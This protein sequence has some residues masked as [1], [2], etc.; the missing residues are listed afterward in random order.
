MSFIPVSNYRDFLSFSYFKMS[1][2][3]EQGSRI[4]KAEATVMQSSIK[5][6]PKAGCK[7][8]SGG[9]F[10]LLFSTKKVR[11]RLLNLFVIFFLLLDNQKVK[12]KNCKL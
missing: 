1:S 8:F 5:T 11:Q 7:S 2:I 6:F 10:V 3:Q 4:P 12:K 9:F